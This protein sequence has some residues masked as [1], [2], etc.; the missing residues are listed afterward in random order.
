M[1]C[2]TQTV[3]SATLCRASEQGVDVQ[4]QV[5]SLS[6]WIATLS[7][8]CL[9]ALCF[10]D[11]MVLADDACELI[12]ISKLAA[13]NGLKNASSLFAERGKYIL[14]IKESGKP[15]QNFR[16]GHFRTSDCVLVE[17]VVLCSEVKNELLLWERRALCWEIEDCPFLRR[18]FIGSSTVVTVASVSQPASKPATWSITLCLKM[19]GT[20]VF[21]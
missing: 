6:L 18:S 16:K 11:D 1:K 15:L 13:N 20:S 3:S 17:E 5:S 12:P 19:R 4:A 21:I 14:L 7:F 8:R 2:S 10:A 9:L